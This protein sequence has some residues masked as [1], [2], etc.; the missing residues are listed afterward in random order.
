MELTPREKDKLLLFTAALLAE[1]RDQHMG[2]L[3]EL[4]VLPHGKR[5]RVGKRHLEFAGQ[6]IHSHGL[7]LGP[8]PRNTLLMQEPVLPGP[9]PRR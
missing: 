1:Q 8:R 5:L 7:P 4:V 6:F 9:I 3:Y 2:G